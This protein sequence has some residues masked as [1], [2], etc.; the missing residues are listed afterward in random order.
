MKIALILL[1]RV[2]IQ[3]INL[4]K[5]KYMMTNESRKIDKFEHKIDDKILMWKTQTTK[6][7]SSNK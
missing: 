6:I 7:T 4:A 1:V 3:A 2:N 5:A